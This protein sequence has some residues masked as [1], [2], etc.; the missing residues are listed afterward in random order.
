MRWSEADCLSRIL[1]AQAS[2]QA[3]GSLIFDVSHIDPFVE[4]AEPRHVR[5]ANGTTVTPIKYH[6]ALNHR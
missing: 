1:L 5:L 2:R 6:T 4:E 3:T